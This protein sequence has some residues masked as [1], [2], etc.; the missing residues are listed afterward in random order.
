MLCGS[1]VGGVVVDGFDG[2]EGFDGLDGDD[3]ERPRG[4]VFGLGEEEVLVM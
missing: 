2:I 3:F 1:V 4:R